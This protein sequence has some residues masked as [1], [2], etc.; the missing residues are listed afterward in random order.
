MKKKDN[1]GH[2]YIHLGFSFTLRI[3]KE[4]MTVKVVIQIINAV[5]ALNRLRKMIRDN[6]VSIIPNTLNLF[7]C[8]D[9]LSFRFSSNGKYFEGR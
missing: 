7:R 3:T 1:A 2:K 6:T 4:R 9:I 8:L 5:D